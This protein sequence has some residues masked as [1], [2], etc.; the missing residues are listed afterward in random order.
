MS[1]PGLAALNRVFTNNA[2]ISP[3]AT[4]NN[5]IVERKNFSMAHPQRLPEGDLTNLLNTFNFDSLDK[6]SNGLLKGSRT[7]G[8]WF[9]LTPGVIKFAG[10]GNSSELPSEDPPSEEPPTEE[11]PVE[12]PE[13]SFDF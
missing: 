5:S 10:G 6:E 13:R 11:P 4:S 1:F 2:R 8:G 3:D 9:H 7:G 12:Y